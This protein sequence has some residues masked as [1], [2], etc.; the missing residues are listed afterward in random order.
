MRFDGHVLMN[1]DKLPP[2]ASTAQPA[3]SPPRHPRS[4]GHVGKILQSEMIS[5]MMF[6]PQ[7]SGQADRTW[8]LR[9]A[10]PLATLVA[11]DAGAQSAV[12]GVPNAMQ[13]FSQNRDQP[14]QI[15]AASPRDARQEKGS[16]LLRQCEG[17]PG[18]HHHDVEDA[19]GVLRIRSRPPR[20]A[21][22]CRRPIRRLRK[23]APIQSATPGP[24]GV[25]RSSGWR[26]AAMW[27]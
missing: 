27:S 20:R 12:T 25:R 24:G 16:D 19:R 9:A 15:E 8:R 7:Y 3:P 1:I 13:G 5:M 11:G 26:R 18:R 14:I 4:R 17:G 10:L 23:S 21:S 2:A 6:R 22:G